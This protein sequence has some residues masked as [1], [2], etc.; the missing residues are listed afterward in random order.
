MDLVPGSLITRE[1]AKRH[2]GWPEGDDERVAYLMQLINAAHGWTV[3]FCNQ[4]L[5]QTFRTWSAAGEGF[6]RGN[7]TDELRLPAFPVLA[8]TR[9]HP[10]VRIEGW[11]WYW[12][13]AAEAG[14]L[15]YG[16]LEDWTFEPRSGIV[17]LHNG[18][19]FPEGAFVRVDAIV[20]L[21]DGTTTTDIDAHTIIPMPAGFPFGTALF[22]AGAKG[23][24]FHPEFGWDGA[25][26]W[27]IREKV[28]ELLAW[29]YRSAARHQAGMQ[30]V[31]AQGITA[32]Y[33]PNV[34]AEIRDFF[35]RHRVIPG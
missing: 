28:L 9:L 25:T 32:T 26:G 27:A 31:S 34:P 13:G 24:R 4:P 22:A 1:E 14:S 11:D 8:V 18:W 12:D 16:T 19:R 10:D 30:S 33:I 5:R 2:L 17:R 29:Q 23:G 15:R 35:Q 20:G 7:G 3:D 6:L 21:A